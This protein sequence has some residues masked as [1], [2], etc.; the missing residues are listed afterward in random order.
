M[1]TIKKSKKNAPVA[2]A[3]KEFVFDPSKEISK[4][5]PR[6]GKRLPFLRTLRKLGAFDLSSGQTAEDI[7]LASEGTLTVQD[8]KHYGY[9]SKN[10]KQFSD[11]VVNGFVGRGILP[12][13]TKLG[14]FLLP[15]A[16]ELLDSLTV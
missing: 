9:L 16:I 3:K 5:D 2:P 14:Y 12:G 8:A 10:G 4:T 11:L 6:K 13:G 15:R 7:A 1:P